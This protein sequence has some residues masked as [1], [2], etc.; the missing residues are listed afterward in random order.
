MPTDP[1]AWQSWLDCVAEIKARPAALDTGSAGR[2]D[3]GRFIQT[4]LDLR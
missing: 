1:A 2:G 3:S 4:E